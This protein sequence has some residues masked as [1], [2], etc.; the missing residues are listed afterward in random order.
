MRSNQLSPFII[1]SLL[2]PPARQQLCLDLPRACR[3][4]DSVSDKLVDACLRRYHH[5]PF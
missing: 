5:I 3:R 2:S 1:P 4:D